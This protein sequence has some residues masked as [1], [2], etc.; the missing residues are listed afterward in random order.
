MIHD[1][2]S[3]VPSVRSSRPA[4]RPGVTLRGGEIRAKMVFLT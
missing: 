2:V 1:E 3:R 4:E